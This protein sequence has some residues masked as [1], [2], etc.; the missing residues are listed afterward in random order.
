MTNIKKYH[1]LI[2]QH[3]SH[4]QLT[5]STH[6]QVVVRPVD[7]EG[8][9][10]YTTEFV[11]WLG[12]M[13]LGVIFNLRTWVRTRKTGP[14][15]IASTNENP[16][17]MPLPAR[18]PPANAQQHTEEIVVSSS[19][20]STHSMSVFQTVSL[21]KRAAQIFRRNRARTCVDP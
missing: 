12:I 7:I 21:H 1:R 9:A 4:L 11:L 10:I 13:I 20:S 6:P 8:A 18:Q 17:D 5:L 2:R 19:S 15:A 14:S 16:S 3:P